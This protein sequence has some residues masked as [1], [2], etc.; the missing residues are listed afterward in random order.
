MASNRTTLRPDLQSL[1]DSFTQLKNVYFALKSF[2]KIQNEVLQYE[3]AKSSKMEAEMK[4][5]TITFSSLEEQRRKI[6]DDLRKEVESL[7]T[8][9]LES[10]QECDHLRLVYVDRNIEDEQICR[11]QDELEVVKAKL[12]LEEEKHQ[13]EISKRERQYSE[14]LQ[15]YK[16]MLDSRYQK[17]SVKTSK[18]PAINDTPNQRRT[19]IK[20]R[21]TKQKEKPSF[22]WPSL[23]ISKTTE[24][25]TNYV[26]EESDINEEIFKVTTRKK[27]LYCE[28][29]D[30]IVDV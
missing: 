1:L 23:D 15:K 24:A 22:R 14:E 4:K 12:A 27:K 11:L 16:I 28:D 25:I 7:K 6:I 13:E 19:T 20:S 21:K 10:R 8:A 29:K 18:H 26:Q 3:K 9:L 5:M 17:Q 2:S 30:V